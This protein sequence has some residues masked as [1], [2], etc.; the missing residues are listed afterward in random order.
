MRLGWVV[1]MGKWNDFCEAE[2]AK[3]RETETSVRWNPGDVPSTR[4]YST[5]THEE[6]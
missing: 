3:A 4:H 1:T 5:E 6:S 2:D